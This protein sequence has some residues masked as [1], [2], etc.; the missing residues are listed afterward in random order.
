[1]LE[2]CLVK[3]A[4]EQEEADLLIKELVYLPLAIVQAAAYIYVNK[5]TVQ[6]YLSLLVEKKG[7]FAEDLHSESRVVI[8]AT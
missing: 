1:M 6:G 7:E 5:T 4:D 3:P 8:A 2:T